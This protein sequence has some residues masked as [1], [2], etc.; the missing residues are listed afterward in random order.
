MR[1][2][3]SHPLAITMW[4]FSWLER[5][6]PGAGYE[7]WGAALDELR[8]R[9]YDAVRI[10]AWPHLLAADPERPWALVPVWNQHVWG[11]PAPVTVQVWPALRGFIEACAERGLKVALSSWFREDTTDAR[12]N[13][14]T[15][16][17]LGNVWAA[18]L[19]LIAGAGLLE[20]LLYVDLCNEFPHPLWAPWLR[21]EGFRRDTPGG[22]RWMR[23][24]VAAVRARY[25]ALD[26]T[27]SFT[28]EYGT[29]AAQDVSGFDL[30]ELHLW[31]A[32]AEDGAYYREIGYTYPR[33][34]SSGYEILQTTAEAAYRARP[35]YWQNALR[36]HIAFAAHWS[37]QSGLPLATTEC[38]GVVDYKDWP[39]L[40][41]DWVQDLCELGVRTAA[42]T[43]RWAILAT[44]NFC[45]PQ[46]LGIWRDIAWHRRL[47]DV[48]HAASLPR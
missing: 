4:D 3:L 34:D 33:F 11:S 23:E 14:R 42:D 29:W 2:R 21:D 40:S 26:Y 15:P 18:T 28:T 10:D 1:A 7:D 24:S 39:G 32:Q 36:E 47:T 8:L 27:L 38:W 43:G 16:A 22:A 31:M 13:I 46:F 5:R 35:D 30:L 44:S 9:G 6:W 17:E 19:D 41:W 37:R 45:G 20:T 25:P 48:I 12:M